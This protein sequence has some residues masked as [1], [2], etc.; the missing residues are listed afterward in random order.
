MFS[1]EIGQGF[2]INFRTGWVSHQF[3][4]GLGFLYIFVGAGFT[5]AQ[6]SCRQPCSSGWKATV[7]VAPTS[8]YICITTDSI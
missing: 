3:P 4:Y 8:R 6:S 1:G 2:L 7:K 5:P